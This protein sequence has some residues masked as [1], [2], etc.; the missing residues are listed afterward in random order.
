MEN[1]NTNS[2]LFI[3]LWMKYQSSGLDKKIREIKCPYPGID[4]AII[5]LKGGESL[6]IMLKEEQVMVLSD[7]KRLGVME[8]VQKIR[9]E[10]EKFGIKCDIVGRKARFDV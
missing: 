7:E 5:E 9:S 4:Y 2:G 10:I 6:A 3:P 8:W 1:L